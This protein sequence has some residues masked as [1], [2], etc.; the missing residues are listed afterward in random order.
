ML[1]VKFNTAALIGS[2]CVDV[3]GEIS[4]ATSAASKMHAEKMHTPSPG[5]MC[6][7]LLSL[8]LRSGL[9]AC[10]ALFMPGYKY[11]LLVKV[12]RVALYQK[13]DVQKK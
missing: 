11:M 5:S 1:W 9:H 12:I 3:K 8:V 10:R 13:N 2:V 6:Y 7:E 4:H